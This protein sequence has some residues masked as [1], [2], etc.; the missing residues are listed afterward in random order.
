MRKN[1]RMEED[2]EESSAEERTS[3][4]PREKY[5]FVKIEEEETRTKDALTVVLQSHARSLKKLFQKY[6][7]TR[8]R[9]RKLELDA[10]GEKTIELSELT[11]LLRDHGVSSSQMSNQDL[12]EFLRLFHARVLGKKVVGE[13]SPEEFQK[14]LTQLALNLFPTPELNPSQSVSSM[15]T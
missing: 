5:S 4:P 15:L 11:R 6:A 8:I 10:L 7:M 9:T 12:K 3:E 2:S 14:F 13:L 1:S